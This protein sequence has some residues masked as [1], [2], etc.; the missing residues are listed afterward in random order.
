MRSRNGSNRRREAPLHSLGDDD[1]SPSSSRSSLS[2]DALATELGLPPSQGSH[3]TPLI[4]TSEENKRHQH[5]KDQVP[6]LSQR[7][8]EDE[9][10]VK[11]D[12]EIGFF[13]EE[14]RQSKRSDRLL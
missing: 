13:E 10:L 1:D 11:I 5:D 14:L 6:N 9:D 4:R 8:E 3:S 2:L 7:V 12:E